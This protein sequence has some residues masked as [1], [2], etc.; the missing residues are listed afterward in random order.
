MTLE[1]TPAKSYYQY[2]ICPDNPRKIQRRKN[3][4]Y[5]RWTDYAYRD[6][7]QEAKASLLRIEQTVLA[8]QDDE[9]FPEGG[10]RP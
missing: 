4:R 5:G 3:T 8:M 10:Q 2:R 9:P 7:P 1:L 6:S